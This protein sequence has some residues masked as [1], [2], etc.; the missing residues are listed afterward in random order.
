[1]LPDDLPCLRETQPAPASLRATP[2]S[3]IDAR[4]ALRPQRPHRINP[5]ARNA[6]TAHATAAV[7]ATTSTTVT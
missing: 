5:I 7:T 4:I 2:T 6:G 1:M 3:D